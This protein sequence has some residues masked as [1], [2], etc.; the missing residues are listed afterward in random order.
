LLNSA[1][2]VIEL[3]LLRGGPRLPV[4]GL[5]VCDY[6]V[7]ISRA[8]NRPDARVAHFSLRDA[9]PAIPVPLR[10]QAHA[11]LDLKAAL[12]RIYDAA[13]Y[14]DYIYDGEPQPRLAPDDASWAGQY[15]P[16]IH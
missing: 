4:E 12:D 6:C 5:P 9:M 11:R 3:D 14:E 7:L 15:V 8:E 1:V 13:G 16:V 10:D 2:H